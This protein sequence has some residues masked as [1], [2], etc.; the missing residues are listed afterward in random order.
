MNSSS[1]T[2]WLSSPCIGQCG[3]RSE[4]PSLSKDHATAE[5]WEQNQP[6]DKANVISFKTQPAILGQDKVVGHV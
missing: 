6:T 1:G 4:S 3:G 5:I 2:C